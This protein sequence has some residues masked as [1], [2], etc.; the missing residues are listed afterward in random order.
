MVKNDYGEFDN[1]VPA[2][3]P[4]LGEA[5]VTALKARLTEAMPAQ[6]TSDPFDTRAIA[7][8]SALQDLADG[9]RDVDAF[10]AL[11]P[12]QDRK[13][14][15]MAAEIGRRL[16]DA[17]RA[18]EAVAILEAATPKK[19][20][21]RDD[22][23][24]FMGLGWDGPDADWE[25]VY[26]DALDATGQAEHVQRLRWAAFEGRLSVERLRAYLKA[27]PDFDDVLAEERAME[28]ALRFRDFATALHF[29]HTWPAHR[30][31]A[32]LVLDRHAEINGN[33][34]YLLDPVARWLEGSHPPAATL[35]RRALIE[36][37]LDG[38]K[39][40]RYRHVFVIVA[41]QAAVLDHQRL[42]S[43]RAARSLR[44]PPSHRTQ[45]QVRFLA[46]SR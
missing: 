44:R 18:D 19:P 25:S 31:A 24:D 1:L 28:H 4:A 6:R 32:Q 33:L 12:S 27:L 38:A 39:S 29:F 9:E 3:F 42:R 30:Q 41:C 16:L 36:D 40:K 23:E 5:G 35:L 2:I 20:P 37:T 46:T 14:P 45:P 21:R 11:V 10:I 22:L 8:R 7:L 34:Y 15:S 17:G 26:L 13:R 43:V